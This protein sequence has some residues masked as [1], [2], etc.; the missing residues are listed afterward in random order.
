VLT[1]PASLTQ[2]EQLHVIGDAV[3]RPLRFEELPPES[4]RRELLTVTTASIADMPL[5]AYAA[6]V[7]RPALVTST[8]ADVTG[9]PARSFHRWAVDHVADFLTGGK[10]RDFDHRV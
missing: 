5:N 6:A 8:V 10:T 3:G 2:R 9:A 4:A 7:D 1:G